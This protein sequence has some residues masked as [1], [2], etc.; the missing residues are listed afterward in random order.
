ME[1]V[2]AVM[3]RRRG[4]LSWS[5]FDEETHDPP[6][7]PCCRGESV[8]APMEVV[9]RVREAVAEM[10]KERKGK[11]SLLRI[12]EVLGTVEAIENEW[13][14]QQVW[15]R[16]GAD[17]EFGL[18]MPARLW[19]CPPK[20]SRLPQRPEV[21]V[22]VDSLARS[23]L[24]EESELMEFDGGDVAGGGVAAGGVAAGDVAAGGGGGGGDGVGVVGGGEEESSEEE[25]PAEVA[26][27]EEKVARAKAA[28]EKEKARK[29]EVKR[30]KNEKQR[31]VK[32][33]QRELV[34]QHE[35]KEKEVKEREL[36]EKKRELARMTEECRKA[37]EALLPPVAKRQRDLPPRSPRSGQASPASGFRGSGGRPFYGRS[38][39]RGRGGGGGRGFNRDHGGFRQPQ[40]RGH[41]EIA[42]HYREATETLNVSSA[43]AGSSDS[44]MDPGVLAGLRLLGALAPSFSP[45]AASTSSPRSSSSSSSRGRGGMAPPSPRFTLARDGSS[46]AGSG[47]S[48]AGASQHHRHDSDG[49]RQSRQQQR[50]QRLPRSDDGSRGASSGR[51]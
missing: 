33:E 35:A 19:G 2:T 21:P 6:R 18:W 10:M 26:A 45:V 3:R 27:M 14:R 47:G 9:V 50:Q 20:A 16:G 13:R 11:G 4:C 15:Q 40:S 22:S 48:D 37:E 41:Y 12:G 32:K 34:K 25:D 51:R 31:L 38:F 29:K 36:D 1:A 42:E 8:L 7:W 28:V 49:Q 24:D 44:S 23:L 46:A 17:P 30:K 39:G 5:W 43:S